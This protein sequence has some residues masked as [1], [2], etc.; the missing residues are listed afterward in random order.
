M[1]RKRQREKKKSTSFSPPPE[2]SE[3]HRFRGGSFLKE[4]ELEECVCAQLGPVNFPVAC[5]LSQDFFTANLLW[6]SGSIIPQC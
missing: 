5:S 2:R 3:G 1:K 6:W 4:A